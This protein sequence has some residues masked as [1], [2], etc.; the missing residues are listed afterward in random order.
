MRNIEAVF[1]LQAKYLVTLTKGL[2]LLRQF[3]GSNCP[4]LRC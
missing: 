1:R 2:V 4:L 3:F